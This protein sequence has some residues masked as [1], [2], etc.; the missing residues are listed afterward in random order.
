MSLVGMNFYTGLFASLLAL[1]GYWFCTRRLK[2][3]TGIVFLGE[4]IALSLCWCP[5]ALLYII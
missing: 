1:L 5:T 4:L 3:Q 2:L